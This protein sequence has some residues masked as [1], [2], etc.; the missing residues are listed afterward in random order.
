LAACLFVIVALSIG[1]KTECGASE[2]G[3]YEHAEIGMRAHSAI[4]FLREKCTWAPWLG[5]DDTHRRARR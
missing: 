4:P 3:K 2:P 1:G 5:T